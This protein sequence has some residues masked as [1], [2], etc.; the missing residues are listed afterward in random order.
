MAADLKDAL[1]VMEISIPEFSSGKANLFQGLQNRLVHTSNPTLQY[2]V[3]PK[4]RSYA[5]YVTILR[6]FFNS[7]FREPGAPL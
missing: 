5:R 1:R 3:G 4:V 2:S 6:T 7:E